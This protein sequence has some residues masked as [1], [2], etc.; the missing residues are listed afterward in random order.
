MISKDFPGNRKSQSSFEYLLVVALTFA[1][2]VPTSY[3]FYS[4]SKDSGQEIADAQI[5]KI[6]TSII[7]AAESAFHFGHGSK[8]TLELN[9]P[10]DIAAVAI[11]DGRELI[12]NLTSPSGISEIVF[13][14]T[15][16]LTT[17]GSN[18]DANECKLPELASSGLKKVKVEAISRESIN[19]SI[20]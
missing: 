6:G 3:I 4:Y 1:I 19:I 10:K 5:T 13:F 17:E 8:I 11:I 16:N 9:I 12:F 2:I 20:I 14:S 7:D 15:V 18:C